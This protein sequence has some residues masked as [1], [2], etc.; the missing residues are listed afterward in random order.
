QESELD[1]L[2]RVVVL[3]F[4]PAESTI[5]PVTLGEVEILGISL[6]WRDIFASEGPGLRL[7]E[8]VVNIK[9][10]ASSDPSK[11]DKNT[12]VIASKNDVLAPGRS[13]T[14]PS[15]QIDLL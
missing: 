4:Y 2:T 13:N 6:P 12:N 11:T 14:S 15:S 3:T 8:R 1:F 5:S 7:L 10:E 9:D